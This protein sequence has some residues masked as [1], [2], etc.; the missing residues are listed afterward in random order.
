M[1]DF[2]IAILHATVKD[3]WPVALRIFVSALIGALTIP[4]VMIVANFDYSA[5]VKIL[6]ALILLTPLSPPI[7]KLKQGQDISP[8]WYGI[9]PVMILSGLLLI[10]GSWESTKSLEILIGLIANSV[11][12]LVIGIYAFSVRLTYAIT[13][14][15][16][17]SPE[18]KDTV[19]NADEKAMAVLRAI[20]AGLVFECFL[21]WY[22]IAFSAHLTAFIGVLAMLSAVIAAVTSLSLGHSGTKGLTILM[23][24]MWALFIGITILMIDRLIADTTFINFLTSGYIGSKLKAGSLVWIFVFM[25]IVALGRLGTY[26]TKRDDICQVSVLIGFLY[27]IVVWINSWPHPFLFQVWDF[28]MNIFSP[29][30]VPGSAHASLNKARAWYWIVGAIGE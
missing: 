21:V 25:L 6:M 29:T 4:I 15:A 28:G 26:L 10:L 11:A 13:I 23:Y 2:L 3:K 19:A 14:E 12:I 7:L 18:N 17:T 5:I 8:W 30:A 1:I 20:L 22:L 9:A 24:G 16:P 27:L